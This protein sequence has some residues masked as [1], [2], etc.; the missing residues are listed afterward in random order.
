VVSG[1]CTAHDSQ[2]WYRHPIDVVPVHYQLRNANSGFCLDV[3]NHSIA[4]YARVTQGTC[5]VT[6]RSQWW[7]LMD[8]P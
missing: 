2:R 1:R 5:D 6:S 7:Y 3:E 4:R 8:A